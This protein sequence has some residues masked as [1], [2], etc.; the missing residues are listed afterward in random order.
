M[1]SPLFVSSRA[2]RHA[3]VE[4]CR[5]ILD[6]RS[7]SYRVLDQVGGTM[8]S[9]LT[10]EVAK[11]AALADLCDKYEVAPARLEADLAAFAARCVAEQLLEPAGDPPRPPESATIPGAHGGRGRRRPLPAVLS[12]LRS[13]VATQRAISR[14]GF[15]ATY[16]RYALITVR[17]PGLSLSLAEAVRAF[18]RAENFFVVRRAPDDCLVRSLSLYRFLRGAGN[19]AEHVIG[20]RRF[21]FQAHAW[22]E[23][24]GAVVLDARAVGFTPLARMGDAPFPYAH[25]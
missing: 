14:D 18:G 16:E 20:I 10:G 21:P 2:I 6:L 22:V 25:S 24:A 9:I 12:A 5:I 3:E 8:W 15:R 11:D 7:E 4:G 1:S 17:H 13:L 19:P 23:C